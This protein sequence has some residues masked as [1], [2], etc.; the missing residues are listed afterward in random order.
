MSAYG[1]TELTRALNVS[2]VY[3][4][5]YFEYYAGYRFKGERHDFWEFI[6]ADRGA[7]S[8]RA[9]GAQFMLQQG[10]LMLH[11]PGQFHTVEVSGGAANAIVV[12]FECRC[13]ELGSAAGIPLTIANAERALLSGIIDEARSAFSNELGDP[14]Y[15]VLIRR[16]DGTYGAEQLIL[17]MLE[18]LLIKL[19]RR[20]LSG[21]ARAPEGRHT[22]AEQF[23]RAS[24]HIERNLDTAFSL[25]MLSAEVGISP[26][27]LERLC[28]QATGMS[29]I[30]Y[31][32]SRRIARAKEMLRDGMLSVTA[33]ASA[34]GFSSVHYF[35]RAFKAM[36]G[37]S[38]REYLRSIK[39]MSDSPTAYHIGGMY[40]DIYT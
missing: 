5:H 13:R 11:P 30:Q 28:R 18:T 21:A 34:T 39:S 32:R 36:V 4:L 8:V 20:S 37:M 31:C 24:E 19:I 35:S 3:T 40:P 38:P 15:T 25:D 2:A 12:S 33:V 22:G 29:V 16:D 26:A 1:G 27:Q 7:L 9:D 14:G 17:L 6:Y 23:A 10:Q